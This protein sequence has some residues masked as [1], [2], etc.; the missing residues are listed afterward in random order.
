MAKITVISFG[1]FALP[2]SINQRHE[3]LEGKFEQEND[4][5][6]Q[7]KHNGWHLQ[8]K[9][10]LAQGPLL[11]SARYHQQLLEIQFKG[12]N[13]TLLNKVDNFLAPLSQKLSQLGFTTSELSTQIAPVP[14]TLLPGDHFLVKT[15]A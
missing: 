8:L 1:F 13:Q 11:I 10:N 4:A 14:A 12:N 6:E 9:F 7:Q 3:Q 15:K 2:Y 5:D